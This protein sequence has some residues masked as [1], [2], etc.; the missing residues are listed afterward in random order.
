MS[1]EDL[2]QRADLWRGGAAPAAAGLPSSF[3]ELDHEL[4]GGFPAGALTE[5]LA[6]C[7]GIGE[8]SLLI[9]VLVHLAR[10]DRW[11]SFIAPPYIPYAPALERAGVNAS[12]VL[13]VHASQGTD[14]LWAT[15]QALRAGT[16]G[17]VLSWISTADMKRLRRLQLAAE[18]GNAFG[19]IFRPVDAVRESSP[20]S[21]RLRLEPNAAGLAVH[22]LKRRG[23]WPTGPIILEKEHALAVHTFARSPA[24][25][26]FARS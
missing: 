14:V 15:E 4:P 5:I 20:A 13:I 19:F 3:P 16:C 23:G 11:V 6:A 10:Q 26:L 25:G 9:P 21:L 8:L 7:P 18:A 24:R 1:L 22:I 17:A 12:H 2:L